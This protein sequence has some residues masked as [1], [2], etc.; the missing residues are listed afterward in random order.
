MKNFVKQIF[1]II[2]SNEMEFNERLFILQMSRSILHRFYFS[3]KKFIIINQIPMKVNIIRD[4]FSTFLSICDIL[5]KMI[6]ILFI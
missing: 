6:L 3:N 5:I 4:A 2:L 1:L